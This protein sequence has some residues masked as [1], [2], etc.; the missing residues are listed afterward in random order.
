MAISL[1]SYAQPF[2]K[3]AKRLIPERHLTKKMTKKRF[4]GGL[5]GGFIPAA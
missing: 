2:K 5:N 1:I 3:P 4:L